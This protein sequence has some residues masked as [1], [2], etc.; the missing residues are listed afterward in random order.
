M[1]KISF[2]LSGVNAEAEI[3]LPTLWLEYRSRAY[4]GVGDLRL[5]LT[6]GMEF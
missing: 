5:G 2:L 4:A 6:A 1:S 3:W